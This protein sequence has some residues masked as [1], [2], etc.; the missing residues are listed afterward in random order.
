M[1]YEDLVVGTYD[2]GNNVTAVDPSVTFRFLSQENDTFTG[3]YSSDQSFEYPNAVPTVFSAQYGYWV[4][5]YDVIVYRDSY[6]TAYTTG[7]DT[8]GDMVIWK[9]T[10]P[11]L[12]QYRL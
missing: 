7:T 5:P 6:N 8:N 4:N 2:S 9:S 11:F 3:T 12:G 1:K 10:A